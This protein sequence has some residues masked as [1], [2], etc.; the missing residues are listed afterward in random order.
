VVKTSWGGYGV[1]RGDS[2]DQ[3]YMEIHSSRCAISSSNSWHVFKW[4]NLLRWSSCHSIILWA[5]EDSR[6][7]TSLERINFFSY[8]IVNIVFLRGIWIPQ[9]DSLSTPWTILVSLLLWN[10]GLVGGTKYP[11][12]PHQKKRIYTTFLKESYFW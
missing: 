12:M 9:V 8:L 5:W 11:K 6:K 3:S 2:K 1:S 7:N 4:V 10:Q